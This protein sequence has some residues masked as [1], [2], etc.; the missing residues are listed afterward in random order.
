MNLCEYLKDSFINYC[1][2]YKPQAIISKKTE[3][4]LKDNKGRNLINWIKTFIKDGKIYSDTLLWNGNRRLVIKDLLSGK[5][6]EQRQEVGI[7]TTRAIYNE[8]ENLTSLQKFHDN[9]YFS[10]LYSW[11]RDNDGRL[12]KVYKENFEDNNPYA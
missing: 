7:Y 1:E 11:K 3:S 12:V 5:K 2:G 9:R 4:V 8:N 10:I 6:L